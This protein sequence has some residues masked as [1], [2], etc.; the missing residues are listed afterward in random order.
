MK[1]FTLILLFVFSIF[2]CRSQNATTSI[3][4]FIEY[5]EGNNLGNRN[6]I[7]LDSIASIIRK[8]KSAYSVSFI[9][10]CKGTIY[11]RKSSIMKS[12]FIYYYLLKAGVDSSRIS[13]NKMG[14][15]TKQNLTY[16]LLLSK[17]K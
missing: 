4:C 3:K 8:S 9:T 2:I 13:Y 14:F 11:Q 5:F 1:K 6:S 16:N 7:K 15:V 12:K 10:C 17:K